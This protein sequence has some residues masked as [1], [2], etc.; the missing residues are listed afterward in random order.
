MIK[1]IFISSIIITLLCV[2]GLFAADPIGQVEYIEGTVDILRNSEVLGPAEVDFG[3]ELENFD[4]IETGKDGQLEISFY[5]STG[6]P[7]YITV[8]PSSSFYLKMSKIEGK[9]RNTVEMMVGTIAVNVKRL[10][11]ASEFNVGTDTV[12]M[13]V[14]G[15]TFKVDSSATGNHL[16][17]CSE[18]KVVCKGSDGTTLTAEPGTVVEKA[19]GSAIR[20][21]PVA[22]SSIEEFRQ[23]WITEQSDALK[24][25]A[26]RAIRDYAQR[27]DEKYD[28]FQKAFSN[29]KE[30]DDIITKWIQQNKEGT[31][32]GRIEN[33]KD[34]KALIRPLMDLRKVLFF[35]ERIYYRVLELKEYYEDGYGHGQLRPGYTAADFFYKL[36]NNRRKL[37]QQMSYVKYVN[38]L[39]AERNNGSL[40]FD[41]SDSGMDTGMSSEF[42]N[43]SSSS[44]DDDFDSGFGD[45]DN[46]GN[47]D[48]DFLW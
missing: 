37:Q 46:S 24:A 29:L 6:A 21:I 8:E 27:Y 28:E 38:K 25:N 30:H 34:K 10:S 3:T 23:E 32:G 41:F 35:F 11:G 7:A 48:D 33:M 22:V 42:G 14:R 5:E 44:F 47:K 12:A 18:G 20:E 26:L 1:R 31:T 2:T 43:S 19:A 15:T 45:S 13:G 17:A 40:P 39:Y 36:E 9:T 4:I 16:I